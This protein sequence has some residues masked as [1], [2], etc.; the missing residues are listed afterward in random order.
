M[1]FTSSIFLCAHVCVCVCNLGTYKLK[2]CSL[3]GST[4]GP[5]RLI[6]ALPDQLFLHKARVPNLQFSIHPGSK[7]CG[8]ENK[9]AT[10]KKNKIQHTRLPVSKEEWRESADHGTACFRYAESL[11]LSLL[12]GQDPPPHPDGYTVVARGQKVKSQAGWLAIR[13]LMCCISGTANVSC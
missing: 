9:T 12:L 11:E 6:C 1:V 7:K 13:A 3:S 4:D 8:T 10:K 2:T 5:P